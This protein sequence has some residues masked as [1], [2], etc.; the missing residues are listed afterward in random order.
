MIE[1]LDDFIPLIVPDVVGAPDNIVKLRLKEAFRR[2]CSDTEAWIEDV[3]MDEVADQTTYD[4]ALTNE[5]MIQ[6]VIY[7][8]AKSVSTDDFD[9]LSDIDPSQYE[10]DGNSIVFYSD[11]AP[12]YDITDGVKVRASLRPTMDFEEVV[13]DFL[14]RYA[15]G[16]INLA[17]YYIMKTPGKPYSNPA[18]AMQCYNEYRNTIISAK[19]EKAVKHKAQSLMVAQLGGRL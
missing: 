14:D 10:V 9:K 19:R 1:R 7:V 11:Y 3:V 13:D 16:I 18:Y 17:K 6:R 5:A 4:V 8:R 12:K 15:D 2:F